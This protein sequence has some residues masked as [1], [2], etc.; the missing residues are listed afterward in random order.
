M[1]HETPLNSSVSVSPV[2]AATTTGSRRP[3]ADAD[4]DDNPSTHADGTFTAVLTEKVMQQQQMQETRE[5]QVAGPISSLDPSMIP[6][7]VRSPPPSTFGQSINYNRVNVPGGAEEICT[8]SSRY[9][10]SETTAI[11]PGP[12]TIPVTNSWSWSEQLFFS[13]D[14]ESVDLSVQSMDLDDGP[15]DILPSKSESIDYQASFPNIGSLPNPWDVQKTREG[16][17]DDDTCNNTVQAASQRTNKAHRASTV[18]AFVIFL[19]ALFGIGMLSNPKVMGEVGLLLGTFCHLLIVVGCAFACYLLLSARQ[20]AKM[21]I[22]ANQCRENEKREEYEMWR[23]DTMKHMETSIKMGRSRTPQTKNCG[24]ANQSSGI[25]K[26][27][28]ASQIADTRGNTTGESDWD[29]PPIPLSTVVAIAAPEKFIDSSSCVNLQ[30]LP[31]EGNIRRIESLDSKPTNESNRSSTVSDEYQ[32][33][34]DKSYIDFTPL[35]APPP[36]NKASHVRLVTYGDVAKCLVG[37]RASFFVIFAMVM[38]HLMFAS[39]MLHL[40]IENLCYVAG[41]ER[42]GWS[43][44]YVEE[45]SYVEENDNDS[46]RMLRRLGPSQDQGGE[47]QHSSLD[48]SEYYNQGYASRST[49]EEEYYLEWKGPDFIGR[50]AMASLLF[51]IIHG[52]LQIPSLTELAAISSFGLITYAVGCIGSMLYAALVLTDGHPFV[53]RPDD[54]WTTKWSGVPTY[55]ATTIYCIEGINLALPTVNSIEGTQRWGSRS[56]QNQTVN[57]GSRKEDERQHLAVLI[58]VGGVFMYGLVTLLVS[59]I[60]LAGGLG[61]GVGTMHGEDG[62]WDVT[63]CLNS[64]AVRYVYMLSLGVALVLT[65]PVILYP[66]TQMLEIWLDERNDERQRKIEGIVISP[67]PRR[68]PLHCRQRSLLPDDE[69]VDTANESLSQRPPGIDYGGAE[70]R[71]LNTSPCAG[72]YTAPNCSKT[73]ETTRN[74][75]NVGMERTKVPAKRKLKYWKL[76]MLL[77]FAICFIGTIE[78]SFPSVL[79]ASEVIRGVCLSVT[80]LI[81]PPLLY[82]SAVGGDFSAPMA[83]VMALLIGLGLFNIVL[84]LMSVF[85]S[86]DFIV[87]EGRGNYFYDL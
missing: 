45:Y 17:N 13:Q 5:M 25:D 79:K 19:K 51:P 11:T 35:S 80:G 37:K 27:D 36:P 6:S 58:V 48:E 44:T 83:A 8:D 49:D 23:K 52:L 63:Y 39:G 75:T 61:G 73:V 60:G 15:D 85:G 81:V 54:M 32:R 29:V 77:A 67:E 30:M 28:R 74:D 10:M 65:L 3:D 34:T 18:G 16:E 66:S 64:S 55:V 41:W 33:F 72:N 21:D 70:E 50:L 43:K 76:R 26:S 47:Q 46:S 24:S 57:G 42:L 84:V 38:G 82:M 2:I 68:R 1:D 86:R 20:I 40:A 9:Y 78:G 14:D 69:T 12:A 71:N 31:L 22:L 62:C 59:W 56:A 53:D 87:E 4:A 7:L